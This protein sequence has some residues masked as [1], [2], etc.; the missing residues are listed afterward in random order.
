MSIA[1]TAQHLNALNKLLEKTMNK[2]STENINPS[3]EVVAS[4]LD[5]F[6]EQNKLS[7]FLR[8]ACD[9]CIDKLL[10]SNILTRV[11]QSSSSNDEVDW[12]PSLAIGFLFQNDDGE[13]ALC[14]VCNFDI[15]ES[16]HGWLNLPCNSEKHELSL[17]IVINDA[18][19]FQPLLE[20]QIIFC[21]EDAE[22]I[23]YTVKEQLKHNIH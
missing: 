11:I 16:I 3:I 15:R 20:R 18:D 12:V 19:T 13:I 4:H 6:G 9:D 1:F 2:N 10:H 5:L 14:E 8:E 23:I 21:D 7:L 17:T 22:Q